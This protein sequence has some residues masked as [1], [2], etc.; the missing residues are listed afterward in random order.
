MATASRPAAAPP[1]DAFSAPLANNS[2]DEEVNDDDANSGAGA[3]GVF[4]GF[5]RALARRVSQAPMGNVPMASVPRVRVKS[6]LKSAE[7]LGDAIELR[8]QM[9]KAKAATTGDRTRGTVVYVVRTATGFVRSSTLGALL[10]STYEQ[11]TDAV[12]LDSSSHS[13]LWAGAMS[14]AAGACGGAAHAVA[15][16]AWDASAQQIATR[17]SKLAA[18][19]RSMLLSLLFPPLASAAVAA[20]SVR[21]TLLAHTIVH[22]SLF[23]TYAAAKQAT[24][25][26]TGR[27]EEDGVF[28]VALWKKAV[29]VAVSGAAAGAASEVAQHCVQTLED[30]PAG[31]HLDVALREAR[32]RAAVMLIGASR[33]LSLR[34]IAAASLT[35][36]V[37]FVAYELGRLPS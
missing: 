27:V 35:N 13:V 14:G 23:G 4:R 25:T 1:D 15:S 9:A 6:V 2:K 21:G 24:G 10:F 7:R 34:A 18:V 31:G 36:A 16:L 22:A 17:A 33:G 28:E 19:Q 3:A 20:P 12:Q 32:A 29:A 5:L 8:Q 11:L 37:G 30:L 26:G